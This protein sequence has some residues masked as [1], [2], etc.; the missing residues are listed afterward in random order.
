M[1]NVERLCKK[2]VRK[3]YTSRPRCSLRDEGTR[4]DSSLAE[5]L[6]VSPCPRVMVPLSLAWQTAHHGLLGLDSAPEPPHSPRRAKHVLWRWEVAPDTHLSGSRAE[7]WSSC[8]HPRTPVAQC[9]AHLQERAQEQVTS[10]PP[11]CSSPTGCS[12]ESP[13][14]GT[15]EGH[16][17]SQCKPRGVGLS[18]L[19]G[20]LRESLL[21][22]PWCLCS[23]GD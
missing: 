4:I 22:S 13:Q 23:L 9:P 5:P 18:A 21:H 6:L 20:D 7:I 2:G 11:A 15:H 10:H 1:S 16:P 19:L 14:P 17:A 3:S 12:Q 8:P